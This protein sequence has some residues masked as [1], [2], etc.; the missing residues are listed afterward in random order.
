MH[1][2]LDNMLKNGHYEWHENRVRRTMA[3]KQGKLNQKIA[4]IQHVNR[5]QEDSHVR[6]HA[7]VDVAAA[8]DRRNFWTE[9]QR[10]SSSKS[11]ELAQQYG[12]DFFTTSQKMTELCGNQV[13][14]I[15]ARADLEKHVRERDCGCICSVLSDDPLHCVVYEEYSALHGELKVRQLQSFPSEKER[16]KG[17]T[18]EKA[19]ELDHSLPRQCGGLTT[20]GNLFQVCV[21]CHHRK[22]QTE[23]LLGKDVLRNFFCSL[24]DVLDDIVF[25]DGRM[26]TLSSLGV[27][28]QQWQ[29]VDEHDHHMR[30]GCTAS[31]YFPTQDAVTKL[32]AKSY[33]QDYYKKLGWVLFNSA[34]RAQKLGR[35]RTVTTLR[36]LIELLAV[37]P[38]SPSPSLSSNEPETPRKHKKCSTGFSCNIMIWPDVSLAKKEHPAGFHV[39][40]AVDKEAVESK[41]KA[42]N[43]DG[44]SPLKRPAGDAEEPLSKKANVVG[45]DA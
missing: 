39:E 4:F 11:V 34:E 40:P 26:K 44:V 24:H 12:R 7:S 38:S 43:S 3:C 29:R 2:K 45:L 17:V 8:R 14:E 23:K 37:S 25:D 22:T 32:R 21:W 42:E 9:L 18:Y 16:Q 41:E 19:S 5:A 27:T 36:D 15:S 35:L 30:S 33:F 31:S 10:A 20:P 1:S 28:V 6:E 13:A